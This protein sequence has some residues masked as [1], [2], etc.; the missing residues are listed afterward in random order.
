MTQEGV[1]R[2]K[3]LSRAPNKELNVNVQL[4]IGSKTVILNVAIFKYSLHSFREMILHQ[5][6]QLILSMTLNYY[7]QFP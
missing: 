7:T 6:Y 1:Q 4:F 3:I 5:K 2:R